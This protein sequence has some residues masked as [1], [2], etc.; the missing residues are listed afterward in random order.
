MNFLTYV[1][2][3]LVILAGLAVL[4]G[5]VLLLGT[6]RIII[7]EYE[8]GVLFR[9]GKFQRVLTP[10]SY[11]LNSNF[12]KLFRSDM[13]RQSVTLQGQ[14]ILTAD[15]LSIRISL[16]ATFQVSDPYR[17]L[18]NTTNYQDELYLIL[19][20][21]LR[22]LV[23]AVPVAELLEKRNRMGETMLERS[24]PQVLELGVD[25][26][27]VK[28]KDTMFPGELKNIFAQVINARLEGVAA[29][30]RARGE[31]AA[32][33]NLANGAKLLEDHPGLYQLRLLQALEESPNSTII[34]APEAKNL[35]G[36]TQA[37]KRKAEKNG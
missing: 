20:N 9:N 19:Q 29:L 2:Y 8:R 16:A 36:L 33:R 23:G 3:A 24:K 37:I 31:T 14:E 25:L 6:R 17:A 22:D 13:R 10:G 32:L 28:I 5:L 18:N 34:L 1:A 11:F 15:N 21:E 30:E 26:L 4:G 12:H 35:P 27:S 7:Y